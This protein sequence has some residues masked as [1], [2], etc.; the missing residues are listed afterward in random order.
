MTYRTYISN[1]EHHSLVAA[2]PEAILALAL[3]KNRN[4]NQT[5]E[6]SETN[7]DHRYDKPAHQ[8]FQNPLTERLILGVLNSLVQ[9]PVYFGV[10]E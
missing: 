5:A 2:A 9:R 3:C 1:T 7:R 8:G 4:A 10:I 6:R